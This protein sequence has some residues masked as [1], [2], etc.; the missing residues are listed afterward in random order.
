MDKKPIKRAQELVTLSREH[1]H[2][3]LLC[4]KIKTGLSKKIELSRIYNYL[5]WFYKGHILPHF[6]IEEKYIFPILDNENS[7]KAIE[8]HRQLKQLIESD[9]KDEQTL[10]SIESLLN[11]HIRFEERVLFNEIQESDKVRELKKVEHL[12]HSEK[13]CDN[14]TDPFWK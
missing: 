11:E 9:I 5:Q 3:L 14:E 1:H 7:K 12:H 13:F 8:Q 6:E 4:W 2:S 10:R